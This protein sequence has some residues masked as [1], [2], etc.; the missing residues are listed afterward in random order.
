MEIIQKFSVTDIV[1]QVLEI[2]SQNLSMFF[3]ESIFNKE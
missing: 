1:N 3:V 2:T